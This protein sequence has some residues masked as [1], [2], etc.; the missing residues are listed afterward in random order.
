M[1]KDLRDEH[2]LYI[3]NLSSEP[4]AKIDAQVRQGELYIEQLHTLE[5]GQQ[6]RV[7]SGLI[8][9]WIGIAFVPGELFSQ[10]L[11][12]LQD[13]QRYAHVYK[14]D[15]E[16]SKLLEL[17]GN[18]SKSY[19]RLY[20]I[21]LVAVVLNANFD[22]EYTPLSS[23]RAEFRSYSTRIAEVRDPNGPNESEFPVGK[24]HGY[25]WRLNS[26]WRIEKRD[27]GVYLQ[28]ELVTLS[29]TI[30]ALIAWLV[31]PTVRKLSKATIASLLTATVKATTQKG[32]LSTHFRWEECKLPIEDEAER[33][34][35]KPMLNEIGCIP[36][37]TE[38]FEQALR[39][40]DDTHLQVVI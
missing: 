6:I 9:H 2:F 8:H 17:D 37:H 23:T 20:K 34:L 1:D 36:W 35:I 39:G 5:D 16:R 26:Y 18:N 7:P 32:A 15:V 13:Y 29:R 14:P 12:V 22:A 30:P 21:S 25:L 27:G 10:T 24:D 19:L 11:D 38:D 33:N 31:N 4:R 40:V 28:V 3:D